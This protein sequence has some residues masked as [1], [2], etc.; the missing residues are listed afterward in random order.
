MWKISEKK[1][2]T[3]DRWKKFKKNVKNSMIFQKF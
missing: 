1:I 3:L 2:K